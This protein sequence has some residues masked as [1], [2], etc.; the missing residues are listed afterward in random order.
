MAGDPPV[1]AAA[2]VGFT[3]DFTFRRLQRLGNRVVKLHAIALDTGDTQARK[4]VEATFQGI[5]AFLLRLNPPIDSEL[6]W[7]SHR[8]PVAGAREAILSALRDAGGDGIV[9]LNLT[10]GPRVLVVASL[11][12]ALTVPGGLAERI[13]VYVEGESF[14]S[15]LEFN[16]A[17]ARRLAAILDDEDTPE[18]KIIMYITGRGEE[19]ATAAAIEAATGLSKST[20]YEKLARLVKSGILERKSEPPRKQPQRFVFTRSARRVVEG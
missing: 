4:R 14:E 20:V 10:G 7:V 6:H 13:N 18:Y 5:R 3:M 8:R 1:V 12:A 15:S 2:T 9:D 19:G 16:A 17:S 11:L